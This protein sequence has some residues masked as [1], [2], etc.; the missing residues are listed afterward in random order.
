MSKRYRRCLV[1]DTNIIRAAGGADAGNARSIHCR[2]TLE[3]IY[4]ICHSVMV[5][6]PIRIEWNKH[7]SN[8]ALTWQVN[9]ES[10]G[11]INRERLLP[12]LDLENRIIQYFNGYNE[13]QAVSK[14]FP[15]VQAALAADN[16][17][18][19]MDEKARQRYSSV[20]NHIK[21]IRRLIWRNIDTDHQSTISWIKAGSKKYSEL[22]LH[23]G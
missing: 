18:L 22:H 23:K 4:K 13:R 14:D 7:S 10:R 16:I 6:D 1:V 2:T 9:M 11:K 21:E 3:A 12:D 5:T 20:S 15:F 8:Y 17:I 19:S